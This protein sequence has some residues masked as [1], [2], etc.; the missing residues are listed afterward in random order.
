MNGATNLTLEYL[1]ITGGEIG[2]NALDSSGSTG[3]TINNC[4]VYG[5]SSTG[6][7][8]GSTDNGAQVTNNVV[9]GLTD[10]SSNDSQNTGIEI[11]GGSDI[12][13]S[14]VT[15]SGNIVYDSS[16]TASSSPVTESCHGCQQPRLWLRLRHLRQHLQ[17]GVGHPVD[18]WQQHRFQQQHRHLHQRKCARDPKHGIRTN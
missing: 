1:T 10:V 18:A 16:S 6:I 14:G 12:Y 11:G 17:H 8:I 7:D 13:V 15:V 9:Y 4:M 2:I 5:N 3:L